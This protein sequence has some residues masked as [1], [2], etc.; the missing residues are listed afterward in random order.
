M[1]PVTQPTPDVLSDDSLERAVLVALGRE[2]EEMARSLAELEA[3]ATTAGAQPVARLT[4]GLEKPKLATFIGVGKLDELEA[5]VL[6]VDA[7][8]TVFDAE[9][10]P[11]QNRNLTDR[12][13]CKVMDRTELI[14]DI[15]AQR[16]RSREGKLQVE[17]AQL[18]YTLPRLYGRGKLMSRIGGGMRGTGPIGTRGP[19]RTK[20]EVD[21]SRIQHRM[22][23]IRKEL[24]EVARRREVSRAARE[25]A[26]VPTISLIGYTN[27]GKSS[28]LNALA[29]G[30]EVS[31]RNRLFETLDT[32]SRR[33]S[34][35]DGREAI[36]SD[37]V[38]FVRHLPHHLVA[39][40]RATLEEAL[41]ADLLIQVIDISDPDQRKQ[42]EATEEVL[43]ELGAADKPMVYALNKADL[44]A[45]L[46]ELE[47][48]AEGLPNAVI[49]AATTGYGM[50]ALRQLI[51][52][53]LVAPL[54]TVTLEVPYNALHVLNVAPEEGRV[55]HYDYQADHVIAE[56]ELT[57]AAL[58]RLRAYVVAET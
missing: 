8:L 37:T 27:A 48:A 26:G 4:Q 16:A 6:S 9:L 13:P 36:A 5:L 2:D 3:L 47:A 58:G 17:L 49:T 28:L 39:A 34:I 32:T 52:D 45:D 25:S 21:R 38:G 15:F 14:L 53:S 18:Q 29:G 55:L 50:D 30:E 11:G 44:A 1:Q 19:G 40:F 33:V 35:G 12:L 43:Q 22:T 42:Q 24:R 41:A 51:R 20:L 56:A 57:A 31:A 10:T 23:R 54:A 46:A 7:D